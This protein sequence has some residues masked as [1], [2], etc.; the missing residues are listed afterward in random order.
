M[1]KRAWSSLA[2]LSLLAGCQWIADYDD[3]SA[4]PAVAPHRCAHLPLRKSDPAGV[5]I[6]VDVPGGL[7]VWIDQDE[8]TVDKYGAWRAD[9]KAAQPRWDPDFCPWKV[10]ASNPAVDPDDACAEEAEATGTPAFVADRPIRCVDWCDAE[11]YC[12]WAGKRLCFDNSQYG[13]QIP[14]N[15]AREWTFACNNGETTQYPWGTDYAGNICNADQSSESTVAVERGVTNSGWNVDCVN[16]RG[17]RDLLGNVAEW[18][19]GCNITVPEGNGVR[20]CLTKGGSYDDPLM[21][22]VDELTLPN[23]TRSPQVGFRCCASLTPE[24]ALLVTPQ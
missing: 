2:M 14:R 22:C 23:D 9:P 1:S 8:V 4:E 6:R 3:F 12:R 13:T 21:A 15:M 20:P 17:A 19:Y 11:A 10:S 5:M 16:E 18:T 24:E 7:C